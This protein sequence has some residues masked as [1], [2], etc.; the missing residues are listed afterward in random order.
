M[1]DVPHFILPL[2]FERGAA[3][4]AEQDSTDE[5]VSCVLSVLVCPLGFRAEL[6]EYG[7]NDPTFSMTRVDIDT[8]GAAVSRWE[9]RA[10]AALLQSRD[11]LDDLIDYVRV[12]VGV[13]S[14]D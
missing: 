7:V 9:P 13:P 6:P 8:I 2:Q 14:G 12:G 10:D 1:T 3:V 5:I 11:A 4:V